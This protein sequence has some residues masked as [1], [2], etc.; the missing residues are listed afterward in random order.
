MFW[1]WFRTRGGLEV[2]E[3]PSLSKRGDIIMENGMVVTIEP[4]IYVKFRWGK[5]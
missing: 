4:G 2:H 3:K 5:E 1:A